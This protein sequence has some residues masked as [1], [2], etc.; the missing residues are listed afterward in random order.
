M[1]N[2]LTK[3][4]GALSL[5]L[6][7][8]A[9]GV[10]CVAMDGLWNARG[11]QILLVSLL[12]GA[13]FHETWCNRMRIDHH[14]DMLLV[15]AAFGGL[16][17]LIGTR[18]DMALSERVPAAY[19]ERTVMSGHESLHG[20]NEAGPSVMHD[21]NQNT[22]HDM[23]S[24]A[25]HSGGLSWGRFWNSVFSWMTGLMLVGAI[26]P[27]LFMTRCAR[28]ARESRRRWIATH[29]FGNAG[30]IVGMILTGVWI[31]H[32]LGMQM[33]AMVT[34]HHLAMLIGMLVGMT[35]VQLAAETAFGLKPWRRPLELRSI[36]PVPD[37]GGNRPAP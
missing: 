14:I 22:S 23:S 34:G 30:M 31:G 27:G 3:H 36:S 26:V 5:G 33:G 16:G 1:K 24:E 2:F 29:L 20:M 7:I 18:I 11:L 19:P 8:V 13:A 25:G 12:L 17:M 28:L 37:T 15:M 21:M 6:A 9:Q 32:A 35:V 4:P 10:G